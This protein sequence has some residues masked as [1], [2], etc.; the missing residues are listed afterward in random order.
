MHEITWN[1]FYQWAR[2]QGYSGRLLSRWDADCL[3][4]QSL[5]LEKVSKRVH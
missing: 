4:V 3:A 2:A 1:D 5:F